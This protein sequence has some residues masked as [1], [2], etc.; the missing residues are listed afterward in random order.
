ML[1]PVFD[2][3]FGVMY[4]FKLLDCVGL[5]YDPSKWLKQ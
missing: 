4:S 3:D 5:E 1:G 2:N